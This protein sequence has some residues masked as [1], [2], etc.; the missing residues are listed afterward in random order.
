MEGIEK[1]LLSFSPVHHICM[2]VKDLEK[3]KEYYESLGI[4]P[5]RPPAPSGTSGM[6]EEIRRQKTYKE[7]FVQMGSIGLQLLQPSAKG[8]HVF[9]NIF[10]RFLDSHGEGIQHICFTSDDIKADVDGLV[11]KGFGLIE[12][13]YSPDG[14]GEAFL[15]LDP[16]G[17]ASGVCIQLLSRK[18]AT[19][20]NEGIRAKD[21]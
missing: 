1:R 7:A 9:K 14:G 12:A 5:F 19:V 3:A 4:G 18:R 13:Y 16:N 15:C 17:D 10:R 21:K 6:P 2:V 20:L 8:D 11:K